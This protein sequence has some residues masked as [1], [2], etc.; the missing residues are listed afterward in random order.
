MIDK[1]KVLR[2]EPWDPNRIPDWDIPRVA[3]FLRRIG[4][5]QYVEQFRRY[6]VNGQ[7]LILLDGEDYDNM[8]IV[9]RVHIRKIEVE[10]RKLYKAEGKSA[11]MSEA[12][13]ERREIIRRQKMFNAA[14]TLIQ[15][16]FRIFIAKNTAK[17]R[18]ELLRLKEAE[19]LS[20]LKIQATNKWYTELE[21][22]PS[23]NLSGSGW[24]ETK[25]GVK[26]PP[27][28]QFGRHQDYLGVNGW[29]RRGDG[30]K[31]EWM[32]TPASVLDKDFLGDTSMSRVFTDKLHIKGYDGKR[33]REFLSLPGI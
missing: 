31:G 15:K 19:R 27:I 25:G 29:G 9:N 6:E 21:D 18:R 8:Q 14:A 30:P 28:K 24:T 17:L 12:H 33:L 5:K 3:L 2:N 32:P 11:I 10:V 1:P 7:A 16:H 20:N 26:L 23:N 22:L 13:A 4:L